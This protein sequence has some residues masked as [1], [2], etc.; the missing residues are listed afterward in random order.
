MNILAID[1]GASG[2]LCLYTDEGPHMASKMPDTETE[3][4]R[5]VALYAAKADRCVI[6]RVHAMPGGGDRKMGATS[7]FSFGRGYGFL[8]ACLIHSGKPWED[9]APQ[10]WQAGLGI[11]KCADPERKRKLK[12]LARQ[13]FPGVNLTLKTCDAVL[14]AEWAWLRWR[15]GS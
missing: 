15:A 4:V 7:A 14:L 1:P 8:R 12:E 5:V 9:V 11:G 2:G 13:R 10:T 6:E 3:V